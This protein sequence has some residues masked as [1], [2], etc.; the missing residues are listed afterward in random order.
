MVIGLDKKSG[1]IVLPLKEASGA[2]SFEFQ[3]RLAFVVSNRRIM[4]TTRS[5]ENM[6]FKTHNINHLYSTPTI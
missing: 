3:P 4:S 2:G 1:H 5:N 6:Q